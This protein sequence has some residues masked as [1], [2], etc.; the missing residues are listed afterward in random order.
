MENMKSIYLNRKFEA[1]YVQKFQ[2]N[3]RNMTV[4]GW[5]VSYTPMRVRAHWSMNTYVCSMHTYVY[6][7]LSPYP[8][9][10]ECISVSNSKKFVETNTFFSNLF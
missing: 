8:S 6:K 5:L 2:R 7:S 4:Y 10:N 3:V 1:I 9:Q